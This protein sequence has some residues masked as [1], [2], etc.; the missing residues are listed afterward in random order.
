MP[1]RVGEVLNN[2]VTGEHLVIRVAPQESNGYVVVG[3]LYVRPGGALAGE[4]IHPATVEAFTVVRGRVGM[5]IDGRELVAGPG[6][7][8]QVAAGQA[9]DW[10]NAGD[11]DARVVVEAQP[12]DRVLQVLRQVFGL[13]RD[14]K[15]TSKGMPRLLDGVALGREF[16][17]TVRFT[18]PPQLVQRVM[19]SLL[20]P[21]ARMTGHRGMSPEY[22]G[23][24]SYAELEPLPPEIIALIPALAA[25]PASQPRP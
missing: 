1:A 16:A 7:R 10:W 3:D 22:H 8:T 2:P 23:E 9:H 25:P 15:T 4:H 19:F 24:P 18:S 14:G 11:G 21:L 5:R 6:Q 12:G 17:D 13:A 20:G